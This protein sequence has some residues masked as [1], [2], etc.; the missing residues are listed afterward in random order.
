MSLGKSL[1]LR[2]RLALEI[3][4]K[5]HQMQSDMHELHTLFWECTLRCN[6]ACRHCGSDC[7][8]TA[9]CKDMPMSDFLKVVD[10]I[11]PHVDPHRVFVIFTGGEA[12]VRADLECCGLELYRRGY[13]WG[14]VTNGYALTRSRL[15]S[16]LSSGMHSITVSLDGF[17]EAH[18]WLR[19]VPHCFDHATAAIKMLA[20]EKEIV[21]DVV[22]CV[23]QR[24]YGDLAAFRDFLI[25]IGVRQWRIF[26]IF[27]VGRAAETPELQLT[28]EQ[29][30]ELMQFIAETRKS[31][32]IRLNFACEGFLG[33]YETEVRDTFY[34]C[35]A[36]IT[37]ASILNDGS[38]SACPSIRSNYVQGNI[39]Q[40]DFMEVWN[41]RYQLYRDRLWMKTGVCS[42]C[43]IFR[44][45]Q[46]NGFH[47]RD[48][49]GKLLV[50]HYRRLLK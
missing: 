28:D 22:T 23:N 30:T 11:T 12:L 34:H 19:R 50:C 46:G 6:A 35:R 2:K 16:L 38:I 10:G 39:Y 40:D 44:Y 31:G 18:D 29:F 21:W 9:A 32:K 17:A 8:A 43:K 41:K 13:P 25:G 36:G 48:D 20:E 45:C 27:P 15:D 7:R 49:S 3:V 42:D 1:S 33:G 14:I 4:R 37:V 24:N 47:L 5:E 26:T